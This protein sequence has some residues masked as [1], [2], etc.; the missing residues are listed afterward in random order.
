M[1]KRL[2]SFVSFFTY[3]LFFSFYSVVFS[4]DE[5][6][7]S[8]KAGVTQHIG[9]STDITISYSRP[10]VKERTVWGEL[11]PYGMTQGKDR[12]IPWRAGANENTTFETSTDILVE[13]KELKAGK[14][15]L[16]MIPEKDEWTII[17]S[18][19][20]S[21][22]GSYSYNPDEDALRVKVKPQEAGFQEW[23]LYGFDDLSDTSATAFLQWEKLKVPFKITVP[24][25]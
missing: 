16:H 1:Q 6:R 22:W 23:L 2:F 5:I 17:F 14:Y 15:G 4:Q 8:P 9:A 13:G 20:N 11:V 12:L 7:K 3:I 18:N 19:N 10:G 25:Q 21:S 24:A